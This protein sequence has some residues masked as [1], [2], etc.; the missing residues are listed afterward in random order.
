[1]KPK[2][3]LVFG[4]IF[5]A[6]G[7]GFLVLQIIPS[8]LESQKMRNWVATEARVISAKLHENRSE[9]STTYRVEGRYRYEWQGRQYTGNR[10]GIH[11][12]SDNIGSYHSKQYAKL[13][14]A[15]SAG[16]PIVVY[17]NPEAPN[18]AI[19]DR[20]VRMEMLM[21]GSLFVVCFGGIGVAII[22]WGW[23]YK[24]PIKNVETAAKPWLAKH[25]WQGGPIYSSA[26]GSMLILV[27]GAIIWNAFSFP[28]A[29]FV[30]LEEGFRNPV[31][32]LVLLFPLVGILLLIGAIKQIRSWR[33]TGRTPLYLDPFP[34]SIGGNFGGYVEINRPHIPG[35]WYKVTITSLHSYMSGSGKNRSRK[36]RVLWQQS[37]IGDANGFNNRT[38]VKFRFDIPEGLKESDITN[39]SEYNLWRFHIECTAANAKLD[40]DFEVPVFATRKLS[41]I[42]Y[43]LSTDNPQLAEYTL[44]TLESFLKIERK[45]GDLIL[46]M[47][48]GKRI[49][50][51]IAGALFGL[52]SCAVVLAFLV[53]TDSIVPWFLL[54][55]AVLVL[56]PGIYAVGR[57]RVTRIG[58]RGI[59]VSNFFL[60]IPVS[61][62]KISKANFLKFE[63]KD[64][65]SM[66]S[67][68]KHTHYFALL[69][70]TRDG[71]KIKIMDRLDGSHE[72]NKLSESIQT[73][74][75]Y[76]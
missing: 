48:A 38:R 50:M 61:T 17:V 12:G 75:G 74:T 73:L 66:S 3:T 54:P 43:T 9:D 1:M 59:S 31:I 33:R 53:Y 34:G 28:V 39:G 45:A 76:V 21:F 58:A 55:I 47:P 56:V 42:Q 67:G 7:L 26:K 65:G 25:E 11:G 46:S 32:F 68:H 51:A 44:S 72:V 63:S 71:K 5:A 64:D 18:E 20:N 15:L 29:W 8:L 30:Y 23:R 35:T 57:S 22:W 36:E 13:Q 69:A 4:G 24:A 49:G 2:S 41:Q 19:V 16:K 60:G 70:H 37:G 52:V 40:R 6:V 62:K 27:F 14:T 10:I